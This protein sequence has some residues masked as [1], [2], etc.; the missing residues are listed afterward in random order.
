M[1]GL[2]TN[3]GAKRAREARERLGLDATSP[4]PCLLTFVERDAGLP[5]VVGALPDYVAGALVRNGV[6]A[7]A[8]VNGRQW[9]ERQ[10]FTLAHE[11]GHA[12]CGHEGPT[13]DTIDTIF[14]TTFN[15]SE[16]EAN[17]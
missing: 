5:V 15:A 6:G 2:H 16:V 13:V 1:P 12:C 11:L 10:R 17:A 9:V 4:V 3:R 7:V 8:F 14:G